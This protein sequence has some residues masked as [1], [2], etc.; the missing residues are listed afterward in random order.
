MKVFIQADSLFE[1]LFDKMADWLR[2]LNANPLGSASV[3]SNTISVML[4]I[5]GMVKVSL[6][7]R[8]LLIES[9]HIDRQF[10]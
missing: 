8:N 3:V 10:I 6:R 1:A 7:K 5:G 2:K 9:F 4:L